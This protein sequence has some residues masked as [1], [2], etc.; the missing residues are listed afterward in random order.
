[1]TE[2]RLPAGMRRVTVTATCV[3]ASADSP[4]GSKDH[5]MVEFERSYLHDL[6]VEHH[7]NLSQAAKAAG[8]DRRT[9]QRL[10]RKH[11]MERVTFQSAS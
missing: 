5:A 9:L 8:K 3:A 2:P 1:M 4:H 11:C 10:L 6:L 7:G